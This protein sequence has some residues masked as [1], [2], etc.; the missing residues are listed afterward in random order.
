MHEMNLRLKRTSKQ[1]ENSILHQTGGAEAAMGNIC[2][3][4]K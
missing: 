1:E 2:S 3:D 4:R